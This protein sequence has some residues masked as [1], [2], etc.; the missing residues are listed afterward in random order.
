MTIDADFTRSRGTYELN[1]FDRAGQ[2]NFATT[3]FRSTS[4][5]VAWEWTH[6]SRWGTVLTVEGMWV[7]FDNEKKPQPPDDVVELFYDND[8]RTATLDVNWFLAPGLAVFG[9]VS[10]TRSTVDA[11]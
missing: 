2:V 5:N 8:S 6:P 9:G 4:A 7:S 3:P 1:E 11:I 10:S